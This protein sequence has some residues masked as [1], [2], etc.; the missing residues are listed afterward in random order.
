[1]VAFE[2]SVTVS[3]PPAAIVTCFPEKDSFTETRLGV[4]VQ[5][6]TN[7]NRAGAAPEISHF[8]FIIPLP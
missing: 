8:S 7:S 5:A 3:E 6:V 1:V 2:S 4:D